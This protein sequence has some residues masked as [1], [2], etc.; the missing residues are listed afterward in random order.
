[1]YGDEINHELLCGLFTD[2]IAGALSQGSVYKTQ[3]FTAAAIWNQ[4]PHREQSVPS[5]TAV[6]S[7]P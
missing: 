1:M 6:T 3:G 7:Q 4:M 5:R 2:L